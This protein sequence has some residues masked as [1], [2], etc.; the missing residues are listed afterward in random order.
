MDPA[1][2][3]KYILA[4]VAGALGT[5]AF[6]PFNFWWCGSVS[7]TIWMWLS[8][9]QSGFYIGF[10]YGLG[11]FG[12]GVSWISISM[13]EHG[14]APVPLALAMTAIFVAGL[15]IFPGIAS[16]GYTKWHK[17]WSTTLGRVCLLTSCWVTMEA[18]RSWFLTGFPW[19]LLGYSAIEAPFEG[20]LSW[21]GGFGTTALICLTS[22][23]LLAS[24]IDRKIKPMLLPTIILAGGLG[25]NQQFIP[26][27]NPENIAHITLWQPVIPQAIKWRA[28]FQNQIVKGHISQGLPSD[29]DVI[30]WP[31]TGMPMTESRLYSTL[32]DLELQ[33]LENNQ[34][35]ITGILGQH[36]GRYTNRLITVGVGTGTY[37]KTRLVPFGEYV[38]MESIFRGLIAFFDLPMS[39]II[40]GNQKQILSHGHLRFAPLICYEIAY[41]G[42]ARDIARSANVILTVS[43]DTW[44]GDSIGPYQHLQ[45]AQ[46]RARELGKPVVRATND[47]VT[48]FINARGR[49]E[50]ELPRFK[51][52]VLRHTVIPATTITP[53]ARAGEA[54]VVVLLLIILTL[55]RQKEASIAI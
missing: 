15:A 37:D 54:P 51:K 55:T 31:E 7:I 53:Y 17:R 19:L 12:S 11:L 3:F 34:T 22:G 50:K 4:L 44:F 42:Q 32:P 1:D 45:I 20:Y 40:A 29:A 35:L 48:A 26:E 13:T 52:A 43:N 9:K 23:G 41:T 6:A 16:L 10:I 46:I 38:P 47:G 21:V 27:E 2:P 25:L 14:G 8:I 28:E 36:N 5:L 33:L 24:L 49:I 18:L 30:I 39:T